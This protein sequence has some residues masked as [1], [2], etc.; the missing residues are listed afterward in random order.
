VAKDE[1]VRDRLPGKE[2]DELS[3]VRTGGLRT[4]GTR[5]IER[6]E[7]VA[8]GLTRGVLDSHCALLS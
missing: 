5:R 8:T 2:G 1:H 3:A 7:M 6:D 4:L